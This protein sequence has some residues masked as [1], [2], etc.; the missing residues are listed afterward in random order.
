MKVPV[1]I[2]MQ[3]GE[4][5]AAA[6]CM[7]LGHFKK[8][9]PME[10]LR[11]RC[12]TSRNGSSPEQLLAAAAEY[13]LD[14]R[15]EKL[16]ADELEKGRFP[17]LFMWKRRYYAIITGVKKGI[18]TVVDPAKGEYKMKM[19]RLKKL[20]LGKVIIL[21]PNREFVAGGK[22]ESLWDLIGK[23][24]APL[25]KHMIILSLLTVTAVLLNLTMAEVQKNVLDTYMN[26]SGKHDEGMQYWQVALGIYLLLLTIYTIVGMLKTKMVNKTSRNISARSGSG[27]FK[28]MIRQP[29][30]FFERY[31]SGELMS[32]IDNNTR[33]EY[34]FI[35]SLVPR[36]IDA[37]MTVVYI[38]FLVR[39]NAILA[40]ICLLIVLA[41]IFITLRI[42][43]KN[44]IAAK[45][46]TTNT[47]A[48][49]TS[50]LNGLSM[51]DTI[52]STGAERDFY[53][54]WYESQAS[55]SE[56]RVTEA[57]L[58]G[59]TTLVSRLNGCLLQTVQLFLGAYFIVLGTY[60][61]GTM[62]LFQTMLNSM[63]NSTNN[64]LGTMD[65]LKRMRTNVERVNDIINRS[66]PEPILLSDVEGTEADKLQGNLSARHITFRYFRADEPAVDDVSLEVKRGQMVALVGPTGCGKSTLLKILADLYTPEEGEVLYAGRGRREI[67]DVVFHSSVTSVDQES[68]MFDDTI[69][70]NI[71]MWDDTIEDY[72]VVMAARDAQ[73]H[74]R[75]CKEQQEYG[76]KMKENGKNFSGGELQRLELAR[77]LAHE[78]TLLFLDEFTSALDALTEE[79]VIRSIRDKGTTCVIVAHR[80]STII[81]CDRIYVMDHG[82]IVQEGTHSELFAQEGL[83]KRL[84][85]AQ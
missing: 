12:V 23:R 7:M 50:V 80:L 39:Y 6:L 82:K 53:N 27:L 11:E 85:A 42:Q 47:G 57:R 4:N 75:I 35:N 17:V 41:D 74:K 79:K 20:Y 72:E 66:V 14:G 30:L 48:L 19:D 29:M 60:T 83:Y 2:Q 10:E 64:C 37:I 38:V 45:S 34:S 77:A 33:L 58:T 67:P 36:V 5:G 3:P 13:G 71:R 43:E 24:L 76:A 8:Y 62:S 70:N 9:V 54:M 18:A 26:P 46:M 22:K 55:V 81:D 68:V 15:V 84:I 25:K 51:M 16:P 32:R 56:S 65:A 63:V 52:R 31:S 28:K 59:I 49:N 44:A 73:I 78:P 1:V 21:T 40:G 69:Y 61:L